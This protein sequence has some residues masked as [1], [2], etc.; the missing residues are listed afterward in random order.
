[1]N[2]VRW[3]KMRINERCLPCLVNQ[4]ISTAKLTNAKQRDVL[5]KKI[6]ASM[7]EIDFSK[8]NP[9]IV[10][11][12]YRLLK[13][14]LGCDDPYKE[15]KDYYNQYFAKNIKD[16]ENENM[17]AE[18]AIKYAIV[19]NIIDF[20]PVHS[21]VASDIKHYFSNINELS[22][23]INDTEDLLE[24]ISNAKTVLY[25][26]D[27]CGEICFDKLLIKKLKAVNSGCRFY[28]GVRGA[29]VVNDNTAE[30]AYSVGMDEVATIISNGDDSLGTI[31]SRNSDEFLEIYKNADVIIAKGQANFES[32]SE[33][34]ENIYFL[35]MVKCAV[36]AEYIG[37][38]QKSLVCMK[39]C[40]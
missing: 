36:I 37:T 35:L 11:E 32:L 3:E 22:L 27:N 33:E 28:F 26:G 31:L 29:A 18:D 7:S 8:T 5:Y 39:N 10:G 23:T 30:D 34:K 16:Y 4:A 24:D 9:E 20:N 14:H 25:L 17:T 6:F 2:F 21:N 15:T 12:N 38:E 40:K 19:A 1:M 13:K